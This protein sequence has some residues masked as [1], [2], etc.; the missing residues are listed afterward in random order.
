[1][2]VEDLLAREA[3]RHVMA[4][5]TTSG[6]RL[7]VDEFVSCFT[8][9][10]VIESE[11][12][13]ADRA[14]RYEGKAAIRQWQERW[15]AGEGATHGATFVR[16]HLSTC[17]IDL[18]DADNAE[19]RTYWVAW[20]DIGPDHSGYYLDRFRKSGEEW[21]IAHRRVRMDWEAPDSLF[22]SAIPNSRSGWT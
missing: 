2:T 11:H 14:F 21:L 5:Y 6:D 7:R 9:D 10:A 12:V 3:I 15:L 8:E 4:K 13:P 22:R 16:H 18:K 20:T 17:R 1:M 19:A